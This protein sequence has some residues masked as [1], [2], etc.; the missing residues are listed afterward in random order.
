MPCPQKNNDI[1]RENDMEEY[2]FFVSVQKH[3][4]QNQKEVAISANFII[5]T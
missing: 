5:V 3:A 2:L 1:V 4:L